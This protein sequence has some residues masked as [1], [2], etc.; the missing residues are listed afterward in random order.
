M[1]ADG[2]LELPNPLFTSTT[3]AVHSGPATSDL[4]STASLD[5]L[6]RPRPSTAIRIRCYQIREQ[7]WPAILAHLDTQDVLIVLLLRPSDDHFERTA[8]FVHPDRPMRRPL[9]QS[10]SRQLPDVCG[11]GALP[12]S[13][14]WHVLVTARAA[15]Q[16]TPGIHCTGHSRSG[17]PYV[18]WRGRESDGRRAHHQF[19]AGRA[20]IRRA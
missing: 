8:L 5:C 7:T 18:W 19:H 10:W 11:N 17:L 20:R 1:R 16:G 15:S 6:I 14:W 9:A 13:R 12:R 4:C 2:G 3:V